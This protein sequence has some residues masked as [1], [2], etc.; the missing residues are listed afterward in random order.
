MRLFCDKKK[1]LLSILILGG[2]LSLSAHQKQVR[3][4]YYS[5]ELKTI[6]VKAGISA[7]SDT[8][9]DG[10]YY[11]KAIYNRKPLTIIVEDNEVKHIGFS[12]FS[13]QQRK[14]F[15]PICCNFVERYALLQKVLVERNRNQHEMMEQDRVVF[16]TGNF[17]TIEELIGDTT[18]QIDYNYQNKVNFF[19]WKKNE[20]AA[21][22]M[23]F[24]S[25]Y[26][27]LL[28]ME[29]D[30]LDARLKN[31]I[32]NIQ[33][34][35]PDSI[36]VFSKEELLSSITH[37]FYVKKGFCYFFAELNSDTFYQ[38]VE[39]EGNRY[40]LMFNSKY[41]RQS[42][43]NVMT[44]IGL[45]NEF[46][47]RIKQEVYGNKDSIYIAPLAKFVDFCL[48]N[49]CNPYF[50]VISDSEGVLDCELIMQ[51]ETL[52]YNHVM[53]M[54]VGVKDI[55]SRKGI[56]DARLDAYVPTHYLKN[57]FNELQQ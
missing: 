36:R 39:P 35:E 31:D 41:P 54:K 7:V 51:N 57:L 34:P 10:I 5:E 52:E 46:Q 11:G 42:L 20:R 6:A 23:G 47:L 19:T 3:N 25:S 40:C 22:E 8:L 2:A 15:N 24:P 4:T 21:C 16:R 28:G 18:I 45:P 32:L 13:P 14:V 38:P 43:A 27:L 12:L 48:K 44:T 1:V 33:L 50:G 56:I 26:K 53:R 17:E 30:E 55:K 37:D 49:G 9:S 29:M